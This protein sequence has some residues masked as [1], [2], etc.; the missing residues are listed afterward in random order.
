MA[1]KRIIFEGNNVKYFPISNVG[2][3]QFKVQAGFQS[4]L[5]DRI[6]NVLKFSVGEVETDSKIRAYEY[7]AANP[8]SFS[9][10]RKCITNKKE[11]KLLPKGTNVFNSTL[12]NAQINFLATDVAMAASKKISEL[13]LNANNM[14]MRC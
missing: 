7:A 5:E 6:N 2:G 11:L 13:E 10:Y 3:D 8:V 12:R 14:D 1:K 9:Q 4:N